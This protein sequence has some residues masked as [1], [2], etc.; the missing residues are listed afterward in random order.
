MPSQLH[1]VSLTGWAS[2][3]APPPPLL[4]SAEPPAPEHAASAPAATSATH[5]VRAFVKSLIAL[6]SSLSRKDSSGP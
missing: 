6:S 5:T 3:P 1:T 4:P 2:P